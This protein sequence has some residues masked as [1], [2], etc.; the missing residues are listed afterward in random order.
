MNV[1]KLA[2]QKECHLKAFWDR[3]WSVVSSSNTSWKITLSLQTNEWDMQSRMI[4]YIVVE[5]LSLL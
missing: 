2:K 1:V 5:C 4:T 3:L